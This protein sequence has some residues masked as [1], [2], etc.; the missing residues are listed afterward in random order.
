MNLQGGVT[1][2]PPPPA[3]PP[4]QAQQQWI[5]HTDPSTGN[6]YYENKASGATQWEKPAGF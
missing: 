4:A 1:A 5:A 3:A 6:T 2:R